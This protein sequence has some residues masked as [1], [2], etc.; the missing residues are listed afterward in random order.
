MSVATIY[1]C[2]ID[3]VIRNVKEEFNKE[4]IEDTVL[5]QL[6]VLWEQKL[7]LS[8]SV[9]PEETY[10]NNYTPN[11]RVT[12]YPAFEMNY[13]EGTTPQDYS[14]FQASN[15][16]QQPISH[17]TQPHLQ[18]F[19]EYGRPTPTY[20]PSTSWSPNIEH[21]QNATSRKPAQKP[22]K[23][24]P[25]AARPRKGHRG[26]IHQHDGANDEDMNSTTDNSK[27]EYARRVDKKIEKMIK[28][29]QL[30]QVDGG[31]DDEEEEEEEA[32][33][34]EKRPTIYDD[35]DELGTNNKEEEE[36]LSDPELEISDDETK[37]D[38]YVLCLFEKVTRVKN[39]RKM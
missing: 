9:A 15:T 21:E 14:N 25:D 27:W 20:T 37:T 39:K 36:N 1:R 10:S 24:D 5:I 6:Q 7:S 26:P 34:E 13:P 8:A 16:P 38:N 23:P 22:I 30:L 31:D 11:K 28:K 4:G 29:R 12:P 17:I 18:D 3:D 19:N 35:E 33:G 2:I 32:E